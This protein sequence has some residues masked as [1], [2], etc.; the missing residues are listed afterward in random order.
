MNYYASN[1]T[2]NLVLRSY[3][4]NA[5][6]AIADYFN[7]T[8]TTPAGIVT[9]NRLNLTWN[10]VKLRQMMGDPF[11]NKFDKFQIRL[12][13]V[14]IGQTP[15]SLAA[16]NNSNNQGGRSQDIYMRGLPFEPSPYDQ[17]SSSKSSGKVQIGTVILPILG[18]TVGR[19][20]GQI[21]N[22]Q[23]GQSPSFTFS[24]TA[25][26][27][28]INIQLLVSTTQA[29][30]AVA[31]DIN[32]YG[33][34]EFSFEIVGLT[35]QNE[36]RSLVLRSYDINSSNTNT[37]YFSATGDAVVTAAG[38]VADNRNTMIWNNVKLRQMMGDPFYD[39]FN[40]FEIRLNSFYQG[41]MT[42]SIVAASATSTNAR[43]VD[44]Y[45]SGLPFDPSPYNQ[46][47]QSKS[48]GR[49]QIGSSIL[50]VINANIVGTGIGQVTNYSYNQSPS[51]TFSKT[52]DSPTIK[53]E[54]VLA[55]S[56]I[57]FVPA[58]NLVF[59]GHT[60]FNFE[61]HGIPNEETDTIIPNNRIR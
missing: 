37:V 36:L 2:R 41:Q 26:S 55:N 25:D 32:L 49:V 28:T 43:S 9:E 38:S 12:N 22:Y 53:I 50:P 3:D 24:K 7:L 11:Y 23:Y 18:T 20:V 58:T 4:I 13:S 52:A 6:N 40:K 29:P 59:Y 34:M 10:N 30:Y 54:I 47:S 42:T 35:K 16:N 51:Y 5:S 17:G 33:H 57:A 14:F 45:M 1:E 48:A 8:V 39:K 44:I 46:G 21:T 19:G 56:Q 27:P 31:G 15:E 61:I 60:E